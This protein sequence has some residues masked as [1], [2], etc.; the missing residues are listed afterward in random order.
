MPDRLRGEW[1]TGGHPQVFEQKMVRRCDLKRGKS[2]IA[3]W[4][5][6]TNVQNPKG[7]QASQLPSRKPAF[8]HEAAA[9]PIVT[10][11]DFV[12]VARVYQLPRAI[13]L[14]TLHDG[15]IR[16]GTHAPVHGVAGQDDESA[17]TAEIAFDAV[18]GTDRPVLAVPGE[19]NRL[20]VL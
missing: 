11:P 5:A 6:A 9:P 13:H 20:I 19:D 8:A 15:A 12:A 1:L 14:T 16:G 3:W 18:I 10:V 17:V 2:G 4:A 7:L